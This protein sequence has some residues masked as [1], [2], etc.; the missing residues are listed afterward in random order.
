MTDRRLGEHGQSSVLALAVLAFVVAVSLG[1]V[2]LA[3][4]VTDRARAQAAADAAALAG[5]ARGPQAARTLAHD[6]GAVLV[7]FER[8]DGDVRAEVQIGRARASA[9]ARW[10]PVPIP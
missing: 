1:V 10:L 6:D 2:T 8:I 4:A 9:R 3:G 5:A 7:A